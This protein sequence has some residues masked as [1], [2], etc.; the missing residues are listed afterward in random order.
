MDKIEAQVSMVDMA[1]DINSKAPRED[2]FKLLKQKE[3]VPVPKPTPAAVAFPS[4]PAMA[5]DAYHNENQFEDVRMH[6]GQAL[7]ASERHSDFYCQMKDV[8]GR[9]PRSGNFSEYEQ[10][11]EFKPRDYKP[12]TEPANTE[13]YSGAATDSIHFEDKGLTSFAVRDL[14][15]RRFITEAD[16]LRW[17]DKGIRVITA[18]EPLADDGPSVFLAGGIVGCPEWQDEVI[19]MLKDA[20]TG[21][22]YNP[23]RKNFPMDDPDAAQ[24]QI[25]W[26]FN[27]LAK[28]DVFSMWFCNA[29]TDQPICMYELGRHLAMHEPEFIAIG[30][31]PG[32][33]REQDVQIQTKLVCPSVTIS[34]NLK[35]H[36]ENIL[37]AL[38]R[39]TERKSAAVADLE[40]DGVG[41][42]DN[43]VDENEKTNVPPVGQDSAIPRR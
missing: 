7:R 41:P 34:D 19:E 40:K 24:E 25:T 39:F 11:R 35:A 21:V 42:I 5:N 8:T 36:A 18:P 9:I 31:E 15:A 12:V 32:Y 13:E 2:P 38:A 4:V 17:A 14:A 22:I 28:A 26:E 33:R 1:R 23:R 3:K 29:D 20:G 27:A 6:M 10:P 37:G 16:L 43:V 30:V